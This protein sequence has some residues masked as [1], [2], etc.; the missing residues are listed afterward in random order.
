MTNFKEIR[1]HFRWYNIYVIPET[2]IAMSS[3]TGECLKVNQMTLFN[4]NYGGRALTL[5]E[6]ESIQI[7]F[8]NVVNLFLKSS[9]RGN[10]SLHRGGDIKVPYLYHFCFFF[11]NIF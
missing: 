10:Y 6:F 2:Y 11:N 7:Q 1:E 5:E 9:V 8:A 3:V 4:S